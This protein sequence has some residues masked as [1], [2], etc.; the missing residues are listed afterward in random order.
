MMNQVSTYYYDEENG[1]VIDYNTFRSI[2]KE[3][4]DRTFEKSINVSMSKLQI[5]N[6]EFK[7][8]RAD[9]VLGFIK[10]AYNLETLKEEKFVL[11]RIAV[12]IKEDG[13]W[14]IKGWQ[15]LERRKEQEDSLK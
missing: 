14:K 13:V 7:G 9:V 8:D 4:M 2:M 11:N 15:R 1:K 10:K 6:I 12:L 3:S 5:Y